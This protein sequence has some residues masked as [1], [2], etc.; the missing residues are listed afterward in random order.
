MGQVWEVCCE[1][2]GGES[3]QAVS[4]DTGVLDVVA[5]RERESSLL[6]HRALSELH[7]VIKI[8]PGFLSF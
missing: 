1:V 3:D 7:N 4:R 8:P 6:V 2:L 5:L